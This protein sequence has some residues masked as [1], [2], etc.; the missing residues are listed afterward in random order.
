MNNRLNQCIQKKLLKMNA[1]VPKRKKKWSRTQELRWCAQQMG[2]SYETAYKWC[3]NLEQP[4]QFRMHK[5]AELYK[6]R[7]DKFYY[8]KVKLNLKNLQK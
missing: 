1:N 4:A 8:K 2:V 7:F 3:R 6:T 5:L